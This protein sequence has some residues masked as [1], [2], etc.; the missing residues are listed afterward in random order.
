MAGIEIAS[1]YVTL[2]TK[3]PGVKSEIESAVGGVDS[4]GAGAKIGDGIAGGIT[5]KQAAIAGAVG[6]I[7]ASLTNAAGSAI[8][9]LVGQAVSASDATDKFKQSLNFAGLD[10]SAISTA[11]AESRKYADQTVY[12]LGTIQNTTAQLASNGIKNYTGLTQA[13]GNLNAVAGGNQETFKSVAMMLTQ[14]AGAGKLTTENWNQ[15]ADAIPG[16]SGAIQNALLKA[17]AYTGNFRDAMAKGQITSEEFNA[18]L[19]KLGTKPV[20]VEAAKS[21]STFEGAIGNLQASIVGGLSDALNSMKPALTGIINGFSAFVGFIQQ[22]IGWIGPL[23]AGIGIVV[24]LWAVWTVAQW[25]LNAAMTANPIGL[26]IVAIGLLIGAVILLVTHWGQVV[27]FLKTVWAGFIGWISGVI[28]GFVG[29]W[30]GIWTAVGAW[31]I[32]VW[33]NLVNKVKF[34]FQLMKFAL[35]LIGNAISQWWNNLWTG[36]GNFIGGIW[37]GIINAVKGAINTVKGVISTVLGAIS[38]TW[39]RMWQGMVNFLGNVFGG[40]VGIAK[41]PINGIINLINGAINALNSVH[42][43]IPD[44]IPGIG[45]QSFGI[46]LPNIPQLAAGGVVKAHAGGTLAN[47]GEGRYD[48]AVVPLS[49][50]V[51]SQLGGGSGDT[52]VLEGLTL[53]E[54]AEKLADEINV[55]K[56]RA[57]YRSGALMPVGV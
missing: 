48:E 13:A 15:L 35:M 11:T 41:V 16:A 12:D 14:T 8:S 39:N 20:A 7:F 55:K 21:T 30:N 10:T 27:S 49:P 31:I 25:A 29:W 47:I 32:N 26:I 40:I 22:N 57:I 42:I 51:L 50:A 24:G 17:G 54:T 46:S 38:T 34:Y 56:R 37:T 1:A 19:L 23:V 53:K 4:S 3:M 6:G 18:A 9:D 43:S 2:T 33:N 5:G 36:I 28:K 45:G 52:Y 44:W